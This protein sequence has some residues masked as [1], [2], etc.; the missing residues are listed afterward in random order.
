[1]LDCAFEG[2]RLVRTLARAAKEEL[3]DNR[4]F[5]ER[6]DLGVKDPLHVFECELLGK[7]PF[8]RILNGASAHGFGFSCLVGDVCIEPFPDMSQGVNGEERAVLPCR[9]LDLGPAGLDSLI[10]KAGDLGPERTLNLLPFLVDAV[11]SFLL[12]RECRLKEPP[13]W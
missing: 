3:L 13:S 7:G 11:S 1:M 2:K 4:L 6:L 9:V 10:C 8:R 5:K 12:S